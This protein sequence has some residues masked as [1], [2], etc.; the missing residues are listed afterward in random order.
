MVN[1]LTESLSQFL[2]LTRMKMQGLDGTHTEIWQDIK[3]KQ[4]ERDS[5]LIKL[6][7]VKWHSPFQETLPLASLLKNT[8]VSCIDHLAM[9]DS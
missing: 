1:I 2:S 3:I 4:P 8:F 7:F 9:E 6:D 5:F